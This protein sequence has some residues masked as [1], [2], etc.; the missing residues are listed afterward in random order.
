M[1]CFHCEALAKLVRSDI[2]KKSRESPQQINLWLKM[3]IYRPNCLWR[4]IDSPNSKQ[5]L[6]FHYSETITLVDQNWRQPWSKEALVNGLAYVT[7]GDPRA[8]V[9][10]VKLSMPTLIGTSLSFFQFS[11]PKLLLIYPFFIEL[12]FYYFFNRFK[13]RRKQILTSQKLPARKQY[14]PLK[15]LS[16]NRQ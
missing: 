10:K 2:E 1:L 14:Q 11:C 3:E 9:E 13:V 12:L 4:M 6:P 7:V 5:Q 8:T 15:N 16:T